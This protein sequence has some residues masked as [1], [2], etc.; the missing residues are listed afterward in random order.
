[1]LFVITAASLPLDTLMQA[2]LIGA[3]LA[4]ARVAG[5]FAGVIAFSSIGG[6]RM[7]QSVG[8]ACSLLPMSTLALMLHHEVARQ[9]PAFG[10]QVG[11]AFLAMLIVMEVVGPIAVQWGLGLAGETAKEQPPRSNE[12][13][14]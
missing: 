10:T 7:R 2:G 9:F 6:L 3:A 4:L 11:A 12:R 8:L 13:A 14:S 5:K 1:V